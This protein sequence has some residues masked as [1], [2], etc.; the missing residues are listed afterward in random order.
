MQ[1][2]A[3]PT[4]DTALPRL[5]EDHEQVGKDCSP[6]S[7]HWPRHRVTHPTLF[8]N[9]EA[10]AGRVLHHP[11]DSHMNLYH[12]RRLRHDNRREDPGPPGGIGEHPRRPAAV[13]D[14]VWQ[15][16][17]GFPTPGLRL[18]L[19]VLLRASPRRLP[20]PVTPTRGHRNSPGRRA[21]R[22]RMGPDQG[23]PARRAATP[24]PCTGPA[25]RPQR[26]PTLR[27]H[28]PVRTARVRW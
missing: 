26:S 15:P 13:R 20:V 2:T 12:H 7:A 4:R 27:A 18:R 24:P 10:W 21:R 17:V 6:G 22:Q 14:R 25:P 19:P 16:H 8:A 5:L 23:D 1:W 11:Y 28:P 3:D 9:T